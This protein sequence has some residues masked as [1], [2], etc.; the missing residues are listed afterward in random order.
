MSTFASLDVFQPFRESSRAESNASN[1]S[2]GGGGGGGKVHYTTSGMRNLMKKTTSNSSSNRSVQKNNGMMMLSRTSSST[3]VGDDLSQAYPLVNS[4]TANTELSTASGRL[5]A[6]ARLTT[7][8]S[9][10]NNNMSDS[11]AAVAA[12]TAT[13]SSSNSLMMRTPSSSS[14]R[15]NSSKS[16]AVEDNSKEASSSSHGSSSGQANEVIIEEKR[17]RSNGE[18]Y[19][20]HQ[21]LRGRLLGKGGFAKV[22]LC[23]AID[24]GKNYAV[25]VVAKANLVK[26]RA[27]QKVSVFVCSLFEF[28]LQHSHVQPSFLTLHCHSRFSL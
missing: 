9:S 15:R 16:L 10:S 26:A 1:S 13:R 21:Y 19:T 24:T 20:T 28:L 4:T 11:G 6:S 18:G 23:T 5:G 12:A 22:Y 7:N 2:S 8:N 17:R 14:L 25:K 3:G 27:R